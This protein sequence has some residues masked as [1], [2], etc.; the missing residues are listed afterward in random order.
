MKVEQLEGRALLSCA[1]FQHGGSLLINTGGDTVL[2]AELD[3]DS[4]EVLCWSPDDTVEDATFNEG[5][6]NVKQV[7]VKGT[8]GDDTVLFD[9]SGSLPV[10]LNISTGDGDDDVSVDI[11]SLD[12]PLNVRAN[13]GADDDS[14][15]VFVAGDISNSMKLNVTA[16]DGNDSLDVSAGGDLFDGLVTVHAKM[17]AGIDDVVIGL[18]PLDIPKAPIIKVNGGND[19]DYFYIDNAL[20]DIS[21]LNVSAVESIFLL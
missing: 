15:E 12:A 7:I 1:A 20:S 19:S 13:L 18:K 5:F 6:T 2:V 14:F 3:P 10:K 11:D 4:M 8:A 21:H 17:G 16:G 9:M